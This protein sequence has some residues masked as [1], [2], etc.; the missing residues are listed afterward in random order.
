MGGE[1]EVLGEAGELAR[2]CSLSP[3][4]VQ[5]SQHLWTL[6]FSVSGLFYLFLFNKTNGFFH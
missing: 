2:G 5:Q 3:T 4:A 1:A 6:K